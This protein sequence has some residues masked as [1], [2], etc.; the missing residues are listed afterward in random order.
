MASTCR[1]IQEE[2]LS[3]LSAQHHI[4]LS[5]LRTAR[6]WRVIVHPEPA[7]GG[8]WGRTKTWTIKHDITVP[9]EIPFKSR[10]N[11]GHPIS[12][13]PNRLR[14]KLE[15][16]YS[17]FR[18]WC[19]GPDVSM[20]FQLDCEHNIG[21]AQSSQDAI[22]ALLSRSARELNGPSFTKFL[23]MADQV[24]GLDLKLGVVIPPKKTGL[25]TPSPCSAFVVS[26]QFDADKP[27]VSVGKPATK[28]GEIMLKGDKKMTW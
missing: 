8:H 3:I 23:Q 18:T 26:V 1:Q 7:D 15:C 14:V 17:E 12:V 24:A 21:L 11:R 19:T 27:K 5:G 22:K 28:L 10:K 2:Y 25:I 16:R 9:V 20:I 6:T 13:S 4:G